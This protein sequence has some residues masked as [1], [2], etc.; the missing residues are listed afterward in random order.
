[1]SRRLSWSSVKGVSNRRLILQ[2][3]H[4]EGSISRAEIARRLKLS[5]PTV[6]RIVDALEQA[7]LIF[8][9]GKSQ[10][11]GGRLGEL[12]SFRDDAGFVLGLEL[13]TRE[14]RIAIATL[15]GE[16]VRRVART[17]SLETPQ[18]VL[19]ELNSFVSDAMSHFAGQ[20]ATILSMG[21]AVPGVVHLTPDP[22]YVDAAKIFPGL[23]NRPLRDELQRLFGVPVAM[24]NDVNL[25]A[26]GECEFGCARSYRN[27]VYFFAGRGVGAGIVL[28]GNLFR[29]G[30]EA[31][32]EVGNMVIDRASLYKHAGPR[33][34]LESLVSIDQLLSESQASGNPGESIE[35]FCE[36]AFRGDQQALE[37][38][39]A[40]YEYLAI[41]IINLA[42]V[43]DP[44]IVVLGG[45]LA[46]L[47]HAEQLFLQPIEQLIRSHAGDAFL[48]RLSQLQGDAALYGAMQAAIGIVFDAAGRP[49]FH[50]GDSL[51]ALAESED[52][53]V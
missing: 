52:I 3:I 18:S 7:N 11:T 13:G 36:R 48:L 19:P 34:Y 31:A 39:R 44:E 50:P 43:I 24:D 53:A 2:L 42:A 14:A 20:Q 21:V 22:G 12:Y 6:S 1:M 23:N 28:D 17:L 40:M 25:A 9:T 38:I 15:N 47:P 46:E 49:D 29:G 26:I 5:R 30:A 10:P 27:I 45:D 33:G 51:N 32:G 8:C 4:E 35:A 41:A 37:A 16:I